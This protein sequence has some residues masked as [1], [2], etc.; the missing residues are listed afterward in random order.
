M[1]PPYVRITATC[2]R[3]G[4]FTADRKPNTVRENGTRLNQLRLYDAV[5]CP[6]CRMWA[7]INEQTMVV[8]NE[9]DTELIGILPGL[10]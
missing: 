6:R 9:P 2:S 1:K 4:Q 3:H 8:A 7:T 10:E 5:V